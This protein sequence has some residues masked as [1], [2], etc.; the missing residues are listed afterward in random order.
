M[1]RKASAVKSGVPAPYRSIARQRVV[2][3]NLQPRIEGGYPIK[4]VPG[5][6]VHV[7]VDAYADG[8]DVMRAELCYK[9]ASERKWSSVPMRSPREDEWEASFIPDKQGEYQFFVRAWVDIL[10]SWRHG[11]ERKVAAGQEVSVELQAGAADMR[12][13]AAEL[14]GRDRKRLEALAELLEDRSRINEAIKAALGP[15][16][17]ALIHDLPTRVDASSSELMPL[18]VERRRAGFSSWYE[19]FP[20]SSSGSADRH[21]SFRDAVNNVLPLV[22]YMGFDVIYL[23]PIHP[24]GVQFRKGPNNSTTS[25]PGDPGSPWA[26]G[27]VEGGHTAVHPELG[28]LEDFRYFVKEARSHDIEVALDLAFQCSPDHPWVKEHPEWFKWRPDGSVQYAENPP[29]KYQDVLPLFFE[30]EHWEPLW[31]ALRD[32][33]LFWIDQG[34]TIFRVDNPHTKPFPFW[35]WL[36]GSIY[37][38]HP[39][40]LFLSEAFTRPRIMARLA[41]IGFHHSYTYF[42]WK[43]TKWDF[44]QYLNELVHGPMREYFRPNFWPNTPDILGWNLQHAEE[45]MFVIRYILAATMSANYGIYGPAYELMASD[46]VPGKEEY[47]YSE[48]YEIKAW[49]FETQTPLRQLIAR[50]NRIRKDMPALQDTFNLTFNETDSDQLI[51]YTKMD[52]EGRDI[53]LVVVNLNPNQTVHGWVRLP[54]WRIGLQAGQPAVLQDLITNAEY[55][56]A[57]EWNYVELDPQRLPFHLFRLIKP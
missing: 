49:D 19:F 30:S 8:H 5:E 45:P 26:I 18:R 23:P 7:R 4:R 46:P 50:V 3:E 56:W 42:T 48:K 17:E 25:H 12:Q 35:E 9:H 1:A 53:I 13:A 15:E 51:S 6:P 2:L 14:K 34:V 38:S 16:T 28:S 20:R 43:N 44:E 36:L 41:K 31:L 39:D 10:A 55:T 33:V 22:N 57:S 37:Q 21:G 40:V 32:V 27:A 11:L 52:P 47:S 29:K 54:L 24:I